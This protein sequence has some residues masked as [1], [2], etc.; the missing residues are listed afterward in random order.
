MNLTPAQ[1]RYLAEIREA[2]ERTYNGRAYR[3]LKV[4]EDAGLIE[5][6]WFTGG[7]THRELHTARPKGGK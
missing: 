3:I 4:L 5:V 1:K 2:G 6:D 7:Y